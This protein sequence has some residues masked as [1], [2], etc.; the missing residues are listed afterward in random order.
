MTE[1]NNDNN[2]FK[3]NNRTINVNA[4]GSVTQ[5]SYNP[6]TSALS[7]LYS[8]FDKNHDGRLSQEEIRVFNKTVQQYAGDDLIISDEEFQRYAEAINNQ[9]ITDSEV[10]E[11]NAEISVQ[12]L[13]DFTVGINSA[14]GLIDAIEGD[15]DYL[16]G[17]LNNIYDQNLYTIDENN[18]V[19]RDNITGEEVGT[20][21]KEIVYLKSKNNP[22]KS[23]IIN[24]HKNLIIGKFEGSVE[25]YTNGK[26]IERSTHNQYRVRTEIG[27]DGQIISQEY[28]DPKTKSGFILQDYVG[29]T[30][31][32]IVTIENGKPIKSQNAW[33]PEATVSEHKPNKGYET[34]TATSDGSAEAAASRNFWITS[35]RNPDG[36]IRTQYRHYG[37]GNVDVIYGDVFVATEADIARI[38]EEAFSHASDDLDVAIA[39][40]QDYQQDMGFWEGATNLLAG[41]GHVF[42]DDIKTVGQK[43]DEYRDF[44]EKVN[45]LKNVPKDEIPGK[46]AEIFPEGN[47]S[48]SEMAAIVD[49]QDKI[50]EVEIIRS[51]RYAVLGLEH[52]IGSLPSEY[53]SLTRMGTPAAID[54]ANRLLEQLA[55]LCPELSGYQSVSEGNYSDFIKDAQS[56]IK[57]VQSDLNEEESSLLQGYDVDYYTQLLN[58]HYSHMYGPSYA[59][60][61]ELYVGLC[62]FS[63]EALSIVASVAVPAG[64]IGMV[65]KLAT[66]ASKYNSGR[67]IIG[68]ARTLNSL[69]KST[70]V[71]RMA[72]KTST[73]LAKNGRKFPVLDIGANILENGDLTMD[74]KN[75]IGSVIPQASTIFKITNKFDRVIADFAWD[76]CIDFLSDLYEPVG[77]VETN[78]EGYQLRKYR[79]ENNKELLCLKDKEGT[80]Y[81]IPCEIK[82]A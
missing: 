57:K 81:V 23:Y 79:T 6:Y 7:K 80:V 53:Y 41:A 62:E 45:Q 14:N 31:T 22:D 28:Y 43:I 34:I 10:K 9:V 12:D 74:L 50:Q 69:Q 26:T 42:C 54:K 15:S 65:G 73:V 46:F 32:R 5:D 30:C 3:I 68:V 72:T 48:W 47:F 77:E 70:K 2:F 27:A 56:A 60:Q 38:Q 36:S 18:G 39:I 52:E 40:L 1:F 63:S 4:N 55:E 75:I 20:I 19:I 33:L 8:I 61:A 25:T 21:C 78:N 49:L 59:R 17:E 82:S 37:N 16:C 44:A 64:S 67:K 58:L 29:E 35:E 24:T 51:T 76:S 66:M 13:K 11:K 71:G